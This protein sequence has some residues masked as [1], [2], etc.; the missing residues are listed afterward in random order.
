MPDEGH[1]LNGSMDMLA[2]A[3]RRVFRE[4]VEE[5]VAPLRNDV[6]SVKEGVASVKE[7]VAE[8]KAE[9][10]ENFAQVRGEVAQL[11]HDKRWSGKT[12]AE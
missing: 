7:D 5:G 12:P 2:Q 3:M 9:T 11:Q 8:F 6:A 10:H 1:K 4:A